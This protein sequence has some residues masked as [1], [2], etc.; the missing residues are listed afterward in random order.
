MRQFVATLF[1]AALFLLAGC[2]GDPRDPTIGKSEMAN[3]AADT[4]PNAPPKYV[5]RKATFYGITPG[6]EFTEVSD[7][8]EKGMLDTPDGPLPVYFIRGRSGERLGYVL[9]SVRDST[10]VGDIHITTATAATEGDIRVGHTF[11][12]LCIAYPK[13]M[14][15]GSE[16]PGRTYAYSTN[17]AFGLRDFTS[18]ETTIDTSGV[19]PTTRISEIVL[20]DRTP[21]PPLAI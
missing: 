6:L 11:A 4:V 13:I 14:I 16:I 3:S 8:L 10:L 9:P 2:T 17:K 21:A 20:I 5:I 15:R 18:T 1:F 7:R 12:R 19:P